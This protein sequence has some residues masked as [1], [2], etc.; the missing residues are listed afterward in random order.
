LAQATKQ[1]DKQKNI[2]YR[3]GFEKK[4]ATRTKE[5]ADPK[6]SRRQKG[7]GCPPTNRTPFSPKTTPAP[8]PKTA[9]PPQNH[10][11]TVEKLFEGVG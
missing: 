6:K 11:K 2:Y 10:P 3:S 4:Q 7:T 1:N 8:K 5:N 9:K